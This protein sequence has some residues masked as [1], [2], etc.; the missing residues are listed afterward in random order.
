MELVTKNAAATPTTARNT[1]VSNPVGPPK[2]GESGT[3]G[4]MTEMVQ[5][6]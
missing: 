2:A 4:L 5:S 6:P 1:V 3:D